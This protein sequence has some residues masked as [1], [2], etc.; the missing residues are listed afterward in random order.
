[1]EKSICDLRQ[2]P[3][4]WNSVQSDRLKIMGFKQSESDPCVYRI[5]EGQM[6]NIGVH[7]AD[8]VLTTKEEEQAI[9]RYKASTGQVR[10]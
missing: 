9:E 8:V 7:V 2:S 6:F 1:M 10:I 5:C 4:C 3:R